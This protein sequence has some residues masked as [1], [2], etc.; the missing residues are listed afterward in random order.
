MEIPRA[1]KFFY[2]NLEPNISIESLGR[3]KSLT[4]SF[5]SRKIWVI[6]VSILVIIPITT[7]TTTCLLIASKLLQILSNECG[8]ERTEHMDEEY[9]DKKSLSFFFRLKPCVI[10]EQ[11]SSYHCGC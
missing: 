9:V 10:H 6:D 5:E 3:S 2:F 1:N 7:I 11:N 4:K 8:G